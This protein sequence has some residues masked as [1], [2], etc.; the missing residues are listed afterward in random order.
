MSEQDNQFDGKL[1][2]REF[3]KAGLASASI[4][5]VPAPLPQLAEPA[6]QETAIATCCK[7]NCGAGPCGLRAYVVDGV[8]KRFETDISPDSI[9]APQVRACTKARSY[10]KFV[11]HPDRLKYPMKRTGD[12]GTRQYTRISWDEAITTIANELKRVI[13]QYGNQAI[14]DLSRSAGYGQLHS[15]GDWADKFVN[16]IG[17]A[18]GRRGGYSKESAM[19][20]A[21]YMF[22]REGNFANDRRDVLNTKL[23][24][25]W[26]GNQANEARRDSLTAY[27]IARAREKSIQIIYINPHLGAM[28]VMAD[29]WLPIIPGTDAALG[30]AMAYV[31]YTQG[32]HDQAFLDKYT[33]GFDD[34]HLPKSAKP[35]SSFLSYILGKSDN[36]PKTPEWAAPITGLAAADIRDLAIR[37]ATYKPAA[38]WA[39]NGAQR[40]IH[41]EEF[42]RMTTTLACMTAN[43]GIS[44][45]SCGAQD[46]LSGVPSGW[47]WGSGTDTGKSA[48]KTVTFGSEWGAMMLKGEATDQVP[49]GSNFYHYPTRPV[50]RIKNEC[51][52]AIYWGGNIANQEAN[53]PLNL[54][55]LKKLPEF[56]FAV[57]LFMCPTVS[58]ADIILPVTSRFERSDFESGSNYLMVANKVIEPMWECKTD[59]DIAIL[60]AEAMGIPRDKFDPQTDEQWLAGMYKASKISSIMS[61]DEFRKKGVYAVPL[62]KPRV[63]WEANIKDPVKNPF[64]SPSG[65]IEI[66]SERLAAMNQPTI[67]AV[68]QYVPE[69]ERQSKEYPLAIMGT[70]TD[71]F[72][73]SMYTNSPWNRGLEPHTLKINPVDAG[74]R[75]IKDGDVVQ[76][77]NQW[78]TILIPAKLT[79][80]VR[81]G[82]AILD[83]GVWYKP[84]PTLKDKNGRPVD[85]GGCINTVTPPEP[86]LVA[87]GGAAAHSA[88]VEVRVAQAT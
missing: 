38:I 49:A 55:A 7:W 84:H 70:H 83:Q 72:V 58:M 6:P 43:V 36:T 65:K 25:V 69:S 44:G 19:Y 31:I 3:V 40:R 86:T 10:R 8:I 42:H 80:R 41:G 68:P 48:I 23:L 5:F 63:I 81:P 1:T 79:E 26:G 12:R 30:A 17:G 76:V 62:D 67:P 59:R 82:L 46:Y 2:R 57:N 64:P 74:A 9:S 22:G 61:L 35:G 87:L 14:Y 37:Y 21:G 45:G 50:P 32:L 28:G 78:G 60:L 29:W 33:L 56:S 15:T 66:Y 18:T 13:K 24:I 4:F 47:G 71:K 16:A 53:T 52:L 75:G 39:G 27:Y 51:K 88:Y 34:D 77:F 11:Y 85:I 54:E 20:A 73:H